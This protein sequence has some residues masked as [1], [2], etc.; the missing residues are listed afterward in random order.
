MNTTVPWVKATMASPLGPL[1]LAASAQGLCGLWFTGQRH[2]PTPEQV[3][4]WVP[5]HNG[6]LDNTAAQLSAYFERRLRHFD[7]P[8]DLT[9]GTPFQVMVWRALLEIPT[10]QTRSYGEL[11]KALGRPSA[12]RAVGTAIGRNP[13]SI[14][15]PCHRVVG[16]QGAL[17][18]YA[19][20]LDRKLALL[21]LERDKNP[22]G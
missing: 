16:A 22:Q 5:D 8:L 13:L 3:R 7:L 20:G 19:G 18:G 14:V 12:A 21:R 6:L 17:T 4:R 10:G 1:L 15:V 2:H 9:A 11:A